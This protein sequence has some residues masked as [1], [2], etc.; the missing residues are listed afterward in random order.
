MHNLDPTIFSLGPFE[1]RYYGLVYVLGFLLAWWMLIRYRASINLDKKEA[2]DLVFYVILGV[3][4]G[5]RLFSV[6]FWSPGYYLANPIKIFYIWEG[7]MAFHGGLIGVL[8][9]VL[10]FSKKFKKNFWK[11]ADIITLPG[12]FALALGRIANFINGELWGTVT[13]APWCVVFPAVEGCR[14]PVVL[15][16]AIG[17]F[18]L[19]GFCYWLWKKNLKPGFVFWNFVFWIGIGRFFTDFLREDVLYAGFSLGQ[20]YSLVIAL[21]GGF[22]LHQYYRK[23]LR[24][25]IQRA[26]KKL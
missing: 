11:L 26:H 12:I 23:D 10:Y 3:L 6:F 4:I 8:V 18:V 5:A 24:T 17:R 16:G 1:V 21:I 20:W 19:F 13:D 14:H 25:V 7:G 22:F 15:Y 2:E 9:G